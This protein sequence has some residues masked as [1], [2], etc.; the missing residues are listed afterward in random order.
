MNELDY[1]KIIEKE[2]F[3]NKIKYQKEVPIKDGFIDYKV[4]INGKQVGVEVKINKSKLFSAI[5]QL[6]NAKR[7]F[8][9]LILL[10][11]IAFI[12][13]FK[14]TI[15]AIDELNSIGFATIKD[16]QLKIIKQPTSTKYYFEGIR[17]IKSKKKSSKPTYTYVTEKDI[18]VLSKFKN[19]RIM[20]F[21]LAERLN[22]TISNA[23]AKLRRLKRMNMIKVIADSYPKTYKI[24]N[25][26]ALGEKVF[27]S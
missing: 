25:R 1:K 11:P 24:I 21:E 23:Y 4:Q 27:Y 20:A 8:S 17:R 13:R 10:A 14:K 9:H 3:R 19:D 22:T 16:G 7:T 18:E 12:K 15:Q 2:F 26:K 5:G 6:V